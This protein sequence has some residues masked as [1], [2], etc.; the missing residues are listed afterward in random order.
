MPSQVL[1]ESR[2]STSTKSPI[3][4]AATWAPGTT[5]SLA[6]SPIDLASNSEPNL[7]KSIEFN[8]IHVYGMIP[9]I[10]LLQ[11]YHY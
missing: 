3:S 10:R 4:L 11:K 9:N 7:K 6:K 8:P 5:V 1:V 2:R